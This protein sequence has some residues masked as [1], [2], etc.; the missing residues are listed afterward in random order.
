MWRDF[1]PDS[2]AGAARWL[3][4]FAKGI[5]DRPFAY[6]L[7]PADV[8]AINR[9]VD[10]FVETLAISSNVATRTRAAVT[11]KDDARYQA[12]DLCR[13]YA[14]RIKQNRGIDDGDKIN[15]GVRPIVGRR[16][17][18]DCPQTSPC[19]GYI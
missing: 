7:S 10:R 9:V 2:D 8:E 11:E 14:A 13:L 15:I 4:S 18:I 12:K 5:A 16:R 6:M 1:I 19:V 17:R 3:L